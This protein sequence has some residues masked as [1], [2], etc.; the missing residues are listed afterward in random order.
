M[1]NGTKVTEVGDI[2]IVKLIEPY[3]CLTQINGYEDELIGENTQ[4]YFAKYF[5]WSIDNKN[6][7]EFILLTDIALQNITLNSANDF[8]IEYKY[9]AVE[10]DTGG[11]MEFVS[12]GLEAETESG[13]VEQVIQTVCCDDPWENKGMPNLTLCEICSDNLFNPYDLGPANNMYNQLSSLVN[14]IFG[15]CVKYYKIDPNLNTRDVVFGEYSLHSVTSVKEIK[16]MVPDNEFPTEEIQ[17]NSIDGMGFEG[18]E[19]HMLYDTFHNA[20]G[21]KTMP[22]VRDYVWIPRIKKMFQVNSVALADEFNNQYTFWRV[23]LTKWEDRNNIGWAESLS[24]EEEELQ[25]LVSGIDDVFGEEKEDEYKKATKPLQYKTIGT[26]DNDQIRSDLNINLSIIDYNLN[27]NWTIVSK[28]YYDLTTVN[29]KSL[30]IKY[31]SP[32]TLINTDN[33]VFTYWFKWVP[34][35]TTDPKIKP[36]TINSITNNSGFIQITTTQ[37]HRY[38]VGDSIQISGAGIYDGLRKVKTI[39]D[40]YNVVLTDIFESEIILSNAKSLYKEIAIPIYSF[41]QN[42]NGIYFKIM[43]GKI[44]VK[45]NDIEYI[46]D[47]ENKLKEYDTNLWYSVVFSLNNKFKQLALYLY[48]LDKP[49]QNSVP[50]VQDTLLKLKFSEVKSIDN[51]ISINSE[52]SMLLLGAPLYFTNFRIFNTSIEQEM[53]ST[54]LNQMI[55]RDADLALLVDNAQPQLKMMRLNNSH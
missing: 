55:V 52:E 48:E 24:S 6:Y 47:I 50:Q 39:I 54:V 37:K 41:D 29:N 49:L 28:H 7:S 23:K 3:K 5:R 12:I 25:N 31:R 33:R 35:V 36:K 43:N 1:I 18:F 53:H 38:K 27:N 8:W 15:H 46:Y 42:H 26:E 13:I 21:A 19:I 2:L 4:N 9:E 14:T 32:S 51:Q 16:I 11:E 44:I 40:Y 30:A 20:F 45:I 10:L 17:Y 34:E 22:K